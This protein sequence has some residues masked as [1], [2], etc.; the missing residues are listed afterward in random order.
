MTRTKVEVRVNAMIEKAPNHITAGGSLTPVAPGAV[1]A[2]D[3]YVKHKRE[4]TNH[5]KSEALFVV[6][7][8]LQ[9]I[10]I[11]NSPAWTV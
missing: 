4:L 10:L 9:P 1:N 8:Q 3:T 11:L 6:F 2:G 7:T 5:Y